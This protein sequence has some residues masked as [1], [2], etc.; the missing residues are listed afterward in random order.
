MHSAPKA[1]DV[2]AWA[3]GPGNGGIVFKALKARN[4]T[5]VGRFMSRLQR[6]GIC[7]QVPA[8][9]PQAVALRTFGVD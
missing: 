2:K 8:A 9:L 3:K 4:N 1:R 6:F 7:W 5:G